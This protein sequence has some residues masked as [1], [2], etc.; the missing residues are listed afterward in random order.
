ML[1]QR[2][3]PMNEEEIDTYY[4]ERYEADLKRYYAIQANRAIREDRFR[5]IRMAV[6]TIT[7][8]VICTIFLKLNFQVQQQNYRVAVL[9]KEIAVLQLENEDAQK[10]IEDA[11]N[12]YEVRARAISLGMGYPKAGNVV[13][14]SVKDTDYMF[15]TGDIPQS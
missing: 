9:Q 2:A 11:G 15:Q 3:V 1:E 7:A 13:Y 6:L 14:Y 8:L 10:R 12:L 4:R 5:L